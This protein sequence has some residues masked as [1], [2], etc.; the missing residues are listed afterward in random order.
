MDTERLDDSRRSSLALWERG[1]GVV[2]DQPLAIKTRKDQ[3]T[4]LRE[5]PIVRRVLIAGLL[6]T[7]W[8]VP[9]LSV[10]AWVSAMVSRQHD[11][12]RATA[13]AQTSG[14]SW[15]TSTTRTAASFFFTPLSATQSHIDPAFQPYYTAH[16]A[17][18]QLVQPI[19]PSTPLHPG[20]RHS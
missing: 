1:R 14:P 3:A 20:P 9:L 8:L 16:L 19:P 12:A 13:P 2:Q 10:N 15:A 17:A 6:T 11:A 18:S 4:Q 5:L 7:L